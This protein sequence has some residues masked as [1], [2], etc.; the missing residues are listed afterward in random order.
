MLELIKKFQ[1]E[2]GQP[3]ITGEEIIN[4]IK[5][6]RYYGYIN[7][8]TPT[9]AEIR[10]AIFLFQEFFSLEKTGTMNLKTLGA[11]RGLRCGVQDKEEARATVRKWNKKNLKYF[12]KARDKDLDP[13]EWD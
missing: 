10:N 13:S 3:H 5:Y 1:K 8:T 9:E 4:A 11:M 2:V 6:L 12:V 7:S